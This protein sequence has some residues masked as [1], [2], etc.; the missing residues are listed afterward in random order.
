MS[1]YVCIRFLALEFAVIPHVH[2]FCLIFM[3][4]CSSL[5]K[6]LTSPKDFL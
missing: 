4:E 3:Q 5:R 2:N 6:V 1:T